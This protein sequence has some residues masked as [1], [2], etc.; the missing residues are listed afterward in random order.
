MSHPTRPARAGLLCAVGLLVALVGGAPEAQAEDG[1]RASVFGRVGFGQLGED[2]FL[3][4]T[5]GAVL[6]YDALAAAIAAPLRF[7]VIDEGA[8]DDGVLRDRDW[9]EA[10]DFARIVPFIDYGER[11]DPLYVHVGQLTGVTLGH[12]T[13][14]DR[15][16]NSVDVDHYQG[17]VELHYDGEVAGVEAMLDNV[18]DPNL[19]AARAFVRPLAMLDVGYPWRGLELGVTYAGDFQAPDV[20]LLDADGR[21]TLT[22]HGE[23]AATS[24][25]VNVYGVDLGWEVV[26]TDFIALTPY[27][28]G[29][30]L[31]RMGGG[32]QSGLLMSFRL[33]ADTLLFSRLEYR[34]LSHQYSAAYVNSLYEIERYRFAS[35]APKI[36]HLVDSGDGPGR[37]GFF[38]ELG[39]LLVERVSLTLTYEDYEGDGNSSVSLRLRLP[40]LGPVM[41]Q[42]YYAKRGMSAGSDLVDLDGMLLLAE[43]RVRILSFLYVYGEYAR[44]WHVI[45]EEDGPTEPRYAT[46]N[47]WSAGVAVIFDF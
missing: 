24:T 1:F 41:V 45:G 44:Q 28:D 16:Y 39:V 36:R 25:I 31:D 9:D 14:V 26:R 29:N 8:N 7:R 18:V 46:L 10:S 17:G 40:W 38:G 19:G 23:L 2:Y 27:V 43:A 30:F 13:I 47:D 32:L 22:G 33:P 5:P 35:G 21:R 11:S 37:H 6:R 12:G 20:L 34:Y 15:Y 42:A 4:T 3:L